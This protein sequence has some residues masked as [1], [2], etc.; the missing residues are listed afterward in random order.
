MSNKEPKKASPKALR[1]VFVVLNNPEWI[2]KYDTNGLEYD[3]EPSQYNGLNEQEICDKIIKEWSDTKEGRYGACLYCISAEGLHHLHMVLECPRSDTFTFNTV[4]KLFGKAHIEPTYGNKQ[5]AEDYINKRGKYEEKGEQIIAKS[6]NGEIQGRQ[7]NR[8][9]LSAFQD[10][11]DAGKT[12]EEILGTDIKAYKYESWIRSAYMAKRVEE[13]PTFR[14]VNV[15]WHSGDSGTGKSYT[16]EKLIQEYGRSEVYRI[17]KDLQKGRFDNYSGQKI[18]FIDDLDPI[19]TDYKELLIILDNY[20]TEISARYR[21]TV[22]L[23]TEVHITSIYTPEKFYQ[24]CV[25]PNRQF[26]EPLKQLTRR[27]DKEIEHY[28]DKDGNFCSEEKG[29]FVSAREIAAAEDLPFH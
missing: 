17:T 16:C 3:R 7:G 22:S 12:P 6:Q 23:W 27:I 20:T 2:I 5:E 28:V 11:L 19:T 10:L 14:N 18:L 24:S 29:L 25:S 9:D 26:L 13:T 4:K 1:S 21:N 15:V 8:S